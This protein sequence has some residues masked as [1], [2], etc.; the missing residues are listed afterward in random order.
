MAYKLRQKIS[1]LLF[2]IF[3]KIFQLQVP[4]SVTAFQSRV[5]LWTI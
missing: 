5:K 3:T 1:N 2:I 4:Y